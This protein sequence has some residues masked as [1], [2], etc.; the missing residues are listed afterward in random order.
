MARRYRLLIGLVIVGLAAGVALYLRQVPT[1]SP[2]IHPP[3]SMAV[4][5]REAK[6]RFVAE[7]P[8]EQPL[9]VA[10][11]E[12]AMRLYKAKPMGKFVLGLGWDDKGNDCSDFVKCC[13]D[14]G[15]GYQARFKRNSDRHIIGDSLRYQYDL[16]W[17]HS[18]PLLPGDIVAVRH[19]PWY[20][21]YPGACWHVGITGA[22]GQVYDFVKLKRWP[23]AR[24]GRNSLTWFT[25]H[26]PGPQDVLVRRLLPEYRYR[27]TPL[28]VKS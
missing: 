22:D 14:E 5:E 13:V 18:T 3:A 17:D 25:R 15:L 23:T 19:S 9:N 2:V 10:I 26:A 20:D 4:R 24:Y 7:H 11:G 6:A 21:P 27:L 28:G 12:A 16:Y 8:G 1:I